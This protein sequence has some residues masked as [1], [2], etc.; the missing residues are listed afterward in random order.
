[1]SGKDSVAVELTKDDWKHVYRALREWEDEG[2][3]A[4]RSEMWYAVATARDDID[5]ALS[6][7]ARKATGSP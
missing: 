3:G 7:T 5:T 6:Q 4:E 2:L 1:M